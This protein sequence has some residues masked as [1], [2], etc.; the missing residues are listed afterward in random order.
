[1]STYLSNEDNWWQLKCSVQLI[2][3]PF[4]RSGKFKRKIL[5]YNKVKDESVQHSEKTNKQ[6]N[7]PTNKQIRFWHLGKNWKLFFQYFI[8]CVLEKS[9]L[10]TLHACWNLILR[11]VDVILVMSVLVLVSM[12]RGNP[13]LYFETKLV[14]IRMVVLLLDSGRDCNHLS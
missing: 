7:T 11:H 3:I 9:I 12:D 6:T 13:L 14:V 2:F 5:S 1:M 8:D 4:Q 10:S